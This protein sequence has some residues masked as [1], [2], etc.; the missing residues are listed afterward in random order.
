[1]A[2]SPPGSSVHGALQAGTGVGC[3]APSRGSSGAKDEPTSLSSSSLSSGLSLTGATWEA[4]DP[5]SLLNYLSFMSVITN[6][7]VSLITNRYVSAGMGTNVIESYLCKIQ[8][9]EEQEDPRPWNNQLPRA[10]GWGGH[11][12][13]FSRLRV[14]K[15][16]TIYFQRWWR[17]S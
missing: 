3:R 8:Q 16:K 12:S 15:K 9:E 2:C 13:V 10:L 17:K 6:G 11:L 7:Y 4:P 5:A 1:M 14:C